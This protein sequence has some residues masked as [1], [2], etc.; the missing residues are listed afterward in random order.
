MSNSHLKINGRNIEELTDT[1]LSGKKLLCLDCFDTLYWRATHIPTDIFVSLAQ[2][3]FF[4]KYNVSASA[5]ASAESRAR[6][7]KIFEQRLSREVTIEE[8]YKETDIPIHLIGNAVELEIEEESQYGYIFEPIFKLALE[9]KRRGI[10]VAV[11]SDIYFSSSQ[12]YGLLTRTSLDLKNVIDVVHTS[13]ENQYGKSDGLWDIVLA[14][15]KIRASEVAHIGDNAYVDHAVPLKKGIEA[16][17]LDVTQ[18]LLAAADAQREVASAIACR[19]SRV[20]RPVL[21][22]YKGLLAEIEMDTPAKALGCGVLGPIMLEFGRR[23]MQLHSELKAKNGGCRLGFLLRDGHLISEVMRKLM[24]FSEDLALLNISR[25]TALAASV[26]THEDIDRVLIDFFNPDTY[27]ETFKQIQLPKEVFRRITARVTSDSKNIQHAVAALLHEDKVAQAIFENSR[28]FRQRLLRHISARTG[29]R[30]GEALIFVDLGYSGTAQNCLH[31]ILSQD[32]GVELTGCYLIS[33]GNKLGKGHRVGVVDGQ[34][35]DDALMR[36]LL[37]GR[38]AAFEMLS[39]CDLPSTINYDEQGT[40]IFSTVNFTEQQNRITKQ[41]QGYCLDFIDLYMKKTAGFLPEVTEAMASEHVQ[42]ELARFS[43]FPSVHELE[44]LEQ[45]E[46][47]VNLGTNIKEKLFDLNT[48]IKQIQS[49]G[50]TYVNNVKPEERMSTQYELRS[51]DACYAMAS[52][53]MNRHICNF[54]FKFNSYRGVDFDVFILSGD[55][56]LAHSLKSHCTY[57][58][59]HVL[60]LP[61]SA[62]LNISVI[63]GKRIC[64]MQLIEVQCLRRNASSTSIDIDSGVILTDGVERLDD[65]LYRFDEKGYCL[66]IGNKLPPETIGLKLIFRPLTFRKIQ[67]E[68]PRIY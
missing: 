62:K 6:R 66:F 44:L 35:S 32:L 13:S 65:S 41:V 14:Q 53:I 8:I 34:S 21:N 38:I 11:V 18:P 22:P 48:A 54:D 52:F 58:G 19:G 59:C 23:I 64:N 24:P 28:Q 55:E 51:I 29:V 33:A 39:T 63:F 42:V 37:S 31:D 17:H 16:Y 27:Q 25:S 46:F 68:S 5:R 2:K 47:D 57:D 45:Y 40:P 4:R 36:S 43:Y 67:D 49:D 1:I 7:R 12:L 3:P 56:H 15:H 60:N 20:D 30:A 9:A 26:L 50:I 61:M 10:K